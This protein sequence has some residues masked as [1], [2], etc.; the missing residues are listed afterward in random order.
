MKY[1]I[2][3][4]HTSISFTLPFLLIT[5]AKGKFNNIAGTIIYDEGEVDKYSVDVIIKTA[6][7][8]TNNPA[9]DKHLRSADFFD[10]EK[11]PEMSF[12]SDCIERRSEGYVAVGDLS[13]HGITREVAIPFT[14]KKLN[15]EALPAQA[16][17]LEIEA[18]LSLNRRDFEITWNRLLD[19]GGIHFGFNI[20]S[21][22]KIFKVADVYQSSIAGKAGLK[23][24]DILLAVDGEP[25][26]DL[27]QLQIYRMFTMD[28]RERVM[29]VKRGE[30]TLDIK[31][32]PSRIF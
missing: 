9:R 2:K 22:G 4:A 28:G 31:L 15:D 16:T 29:S 13:L 27:S 30:E 12:R 26:S 17:R 23:I 18:T 11:Y 32:K 24:S 5:K 20:V 7:I 21:E 8:D 25:L 10:V 3:A 19:A 6:S 14:I 1:E